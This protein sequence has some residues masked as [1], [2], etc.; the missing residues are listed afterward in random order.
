MDPSV[1]ALIGL[2][3]MAVFMLLGM[4]IAFAMLLAGVLG[5]AYLL[6][7]GAVSHLLATNLWE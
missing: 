7:P 5:N 6:P 4:P 1:V 3:V 2:A